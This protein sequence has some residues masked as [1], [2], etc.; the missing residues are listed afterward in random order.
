MQDK[1][2]KLGELLVTAG[3]VTQDQLKEALKEQKIYGKKLGQILV[4]KNI[5]T[6][7]EIIEVLE[8]QLGIPHVNLDKFIID[9]QIP[10]LITENLARRYTLIPIKKQRGKLVV[11]MADPLNIF[12]IDDVKIATG[13]D[14][15]PVICTEKE[16]LNAIDQYYGKEVAEKAI[17]DFKKQYNLDNIQDLDEEILNDINNAPVVRLVNSII[18]QAVKAKASDIHI[19]PF[20]NDVRIRFRVDGELQEVMT[21]AKS[22]HSAIVTRIKIMGKM[23]IAEKRLPQDGRIEITID[24]QEIDLRISILPTVFGEK[25]VIRLL[26]RSAFLL[27]KNQLGFTYKNLERFDKLIK[28]PN[29]IILITGPTGSGKTTTLYTILREL[30]TI[31]KNIITVEDPVE[32]KL[33]GINQVQVNNKAG[34]TF[35]SGLRSILRQDP[36]IVMIGEIRDSETAQIAVRAAITG[37]LV[38]ST[39]HTNDAPSTV[40][41]LVDM[42]I[43]PYLIS[44][45]V[46]GVVAQRLVR[47]ICD[48]CKTSYTPSEKEIK[49]LKLKENDLLYKGTGCVHCYNSGYKGRTSIHEIM[50]INKNIRSL[51][52]EKEGIDKLRKESIDDGMITLRENCKELVLN[53]VTSFDELMRVTYTNN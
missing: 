44:A 17:E 29:G 39:M 43:E 34:L 42:G 52:D 53:G 38:I 45:S 37:H 12:A 36:D 46:V 35:A 31:N 1:K 16:I 15:D 30:N 3:K 8:F 6:E 19:E 10:L 51:I 5:I 26:D 18:K 23:N 40:T 21:T 41:R 25:I 28:N 48:K 47:K 24:R 13:M 33:H 4:D 20:E 7:E 32:Y 50:N 49:T 22:T 2:L 11:A 14:I 27:S 9:A